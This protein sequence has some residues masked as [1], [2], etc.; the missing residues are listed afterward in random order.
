M[1]RS[2]IFFPDS[3]RFIVDREIGE[4]VSKLSLA[5]ASKLSPF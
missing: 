3:A 2:D 1:V 5:T 4:P